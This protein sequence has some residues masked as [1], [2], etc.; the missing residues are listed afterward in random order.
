MCTHTFNVGDDYDPQMDEVNLAVVALDSHPLVSRPDPETIQINI[1]MIMT[2]E[3]F[4]TILLPVII[5]PNKCRTLSCK[6][7]IGAGRN[8]MSK[9]VFKKLLPD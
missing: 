1:L 5:S 6:V 3:A 7:E 4:T 9:H 2:T 8:V